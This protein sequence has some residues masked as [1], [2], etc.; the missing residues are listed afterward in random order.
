MF[1]AR[2]RLG[3]HVPMAMNKQGTVKVLC[4]GSAQRL[5]NEDPR[6][7]EIEL[8]DSLEMAI[9]DDWEEMAAES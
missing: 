3:K 5:Y 7:T 6:A 9:K 2:Q 8:R 1:I 4:V